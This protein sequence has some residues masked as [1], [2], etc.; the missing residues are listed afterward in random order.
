MY[1]LDMERMMNLV[2]KCD[3][4][5]STEYETLM[6]S[7][8]EKADTNFAFA[9]SSAKL[10]QELLRCIECTLIQTLRVVNKE[11]LIQGY[12]SNVDEI[13]DSQFSVRCRTF[14]RAL[15][16]LFHDLD[17]KQIDGKTM[18]DIG[19][20][21]GAILCA[22]KALGIN[23]VGVEP[24]KSLVDQG[25]ARGLV[26]HKGVLPDPKFKNRS[27]SFV[28]TWDVIEHVVSPRQFVQSLKELCA[29][30]SLLIINT[31]NYDSWQRKL[32][33]SYWPFFLEVHLFY[34]TPTTVTKLLSELGFEVTLIR[35]HVQC[36]EL[37]Y[38]IHRYFPN[39]RIS[40]K[41]SRIPIWYSMGQMSIVARMS[42]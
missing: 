31:P 17:V 3:L 27:F 28:S 32:L 21:S 5:G 20:S 30:D 16:K 29:P 36:L 34:F 26:I 42:R 35:N 19:C 18:V 4:C 33:G 1:D 15:K 12:E 11:E 9:G 40:K 37:G 10:T 13:H 7:R 41:V 25:L 39:I 2:Q 14:L 8:P 24:S 6:T 23:A 22:S 38:L